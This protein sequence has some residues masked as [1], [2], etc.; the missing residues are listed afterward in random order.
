MSSAHYRFAIVSVLIAACLS[1][2][3]H[4]SPTVTLKYLGAAGWEITDGKTVVLI[5]P[6]LSRLR[7]VIPAADVLPTDTRPL[8]TNDDIALTDTAVVDAHVQ[9]ADFVLITHTH[10]DHAMD[11]PYIAAKTGAT[12]IGTESTFNLAR[13]CGI[14]GNNSSWCAAARTT[15]LVTSRSKSF[16]A[17][18]VSFEMH[19]SSVAIPTHRYLQ[20]CSRAT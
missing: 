15:N 17:C 3:A 19:L 4:D 11:L 14:P 10:F 18:T 13:V 20:P 1:A 9:R 2:A 7:H 16:P 12:I 5:D 8:F 6:Y